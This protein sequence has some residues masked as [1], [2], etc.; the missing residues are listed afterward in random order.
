M[1]GYIYTAVWLLLAA[2]MIYVT[3]KRYRTPIMF[4][5]SGFMVFLAVWELVNVLTPVDLKAGV[6][7]WVYRGIALV[8]LV[9][10]L[11]WYFVLRNRN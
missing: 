2:Y 5:L 10:C 9:L 4:I 8:V 3:V 7:G 1:T 6:Y 11:I